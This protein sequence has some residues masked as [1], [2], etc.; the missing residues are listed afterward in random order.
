MSPA[1]IWT[2]P[3]AANKIVK[4]VEAVSEIHGMDRFP[5]DVA[6][7][8][9]EAANI[10]G[11]SDPISK[12]Q[13]ANIKGFEGALFSNGSRDEWLLL[14][15]DTMES[16]GRI[17]FTQAHE[18]GHYVLHRT[19]RESFQCGDSDV[20]GW[21][22]DETNLETQADDFASYLL[23][24]MDDF[25]RQTNCDVDL[26]VLSDCAERYGVSLTAAVLKWLKFTEQKAVLIMSKSGFMDW[27]WSSEPAL[28]AGAFFRTKNNVVEIPQ[29]TIASDDSIHIEREG[30]EVPI[31][32]WF[33][34]AEKGIALREMK[35]NM[36]QFDCT[37]TLLILP[38]SVEVW[39][40]YDFPSSER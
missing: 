10:F 9:L 35:L 11:W 37:L 34:D 22:G 40:P 18:L 16:P 25:R 39:P 38:R 12:V 15:N 30:K 6:Q 32:T 33:K 28:K 27:A 4:V 14:Y 7:V 36:E 26:N 8:A 13:A 21:P 5:L 29:G 2:P 3:R 20:L 31:I 19:L 23:M 17:R 1:E 24:P